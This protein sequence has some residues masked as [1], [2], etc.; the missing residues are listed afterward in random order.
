[1]TGR[2]CYPLPRLDESPDRVRRRIQ[3]PLER[4]AGTRARLKVVIAVLQPDD[5]DPIIEGVTGHLLARAERIARA[6]DDQRRAG[7]AR[8][9]RGSELLRCLRR[10]ERLAEA[11]K[12]LDASG[13]VF[14]IRDQARHP[15]AE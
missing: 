2:S 5:P 15:P 6:L 8:E 13:G 14:L 11:H 7:E 4:L 10:M 12:P 3:M 1:M 9:V